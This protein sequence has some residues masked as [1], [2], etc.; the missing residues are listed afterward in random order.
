[1]G[2]ICSLICS[3]CPSSSCI[4]KRNSSS[5]NS[6]STPKLIS[7]T[8]QLIF[9][10]AK[11][12]L[13]LSQSFKSILQFSVEIYWAIRFLLMAC[14]MWIKS[15]ES[16]LQSFIKI[17]SIPVRVPL[18]HTLDKLYQAWL[19]SSLL[20]D[21][22]SISSYTSYSSIKKIKVFSF[23]KVKLQLERFRFLH[24]LKLMNLQRGSMSSVSISSPD[25]LIVLRRRGST[26]LI[27]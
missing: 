25:K 14:K 2:K 10:A 20:F 6:D 9:K 23:F 5:I 4:P 18:D 3:F 16:I 22:S 8:E 12:S 13:R 26:I 24:L 17:L 21:K 19:L 15:S 27:F 7:M 11:I 1:M